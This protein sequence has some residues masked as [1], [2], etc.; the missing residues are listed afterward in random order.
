[1]ALDDSEDLE[2]GFKVRLLKQFH[3]QRRTRACKFLGR[4]NTV[5]A[6]LN[7]YR[8]SANRCGNPTLED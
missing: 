4:R 8:G 2:L 5:E 3:V 6:L 1:M 7:S